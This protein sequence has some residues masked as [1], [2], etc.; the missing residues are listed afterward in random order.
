MSPSAASALRV[1]LLA[2]LAALG[3]K[4]AP[5]PAGRPNILLALADDWRDGLAPRAVEL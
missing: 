3:G 2:A 1:A 4:A 5:A